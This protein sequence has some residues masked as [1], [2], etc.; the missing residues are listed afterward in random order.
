MDVS[1]VG[2]LDSY[3]MSFLTTIALS[4]FSAN[5]MNGDHELRGTHSIR[6]PKREFIGGR[7]RVNSVAILTVD[8]P[9]NS[10]TRCA[11]H[12]DFFSRT[13]IDVNIHLRRTTETESN[14]LPLENTTIIPVNCSCSENQYGWEG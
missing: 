8:L 10:K 7:I 11:Q 2:D 4:N 9:M 13:R 6:D 12:H 3:G 1:M 14:L 5:E